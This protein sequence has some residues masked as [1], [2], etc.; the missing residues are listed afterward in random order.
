MRVLNSNIQDGVLKP[1]YKV[2]CN[3]C[4]K[5]FLEVMEY[6]VKNMIIRARHFKPLAKGIQLKDGDDMQCLF[7]NEGFTDLELKAHKDDNITFVYA[8]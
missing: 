7:C 8:Y 4:K 5:D 2:R 1:G 3:H 6:L